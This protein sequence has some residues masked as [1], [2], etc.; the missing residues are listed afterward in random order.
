MLDDVGLGGVARFHNLPP[1]YHGLYDLRGVQRA[2]GGPVG[3]DAYTPRG[4]FRELR[5]RA[6]AAVGNAAP[7]PIAFEV[8][9]GFFPWF[10]PLDAGDD[11]D[12]ERDHVLS[13]LAAGIRGF[14]LYMA[15][16]RER[17]Y[18]AAIAQTGAAERHAGWIRTLIAA[19]VEVNWPELRRAAAIAVV[20]T[21][22]DARFGQASCVLD[23]LT[24][25]VSEVL[26]LGPG[27]G[28]ELGTDPAAI[29]QRRWQ[30]AITRALDVARVPYLLVEESLGEA[31]LAGMRAVIVPTL[32]R[33]DR[34]LAHT[35]RAVIEHGHADPAGRRT[36]VVIGPGTPTH[37][38]LGQP[39]VDA[40]PRRVGRLKPGSLDDV[41]GLAAD[42]AALADPAEAWQIERPDD[43]HAYAHHDPSGAVR[44]VFVASD[45]AKPTNA[46]L[47][48]D[49]TTRGLR[50]P[51]ARG[52][53]APAAGKAQVAL[54][55]R[56]VRMLIVER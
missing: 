56:G 29:T 30:A 3:I 54:P 24:P 53:I 50:D 33:I 34:G 8:G 49:E 11:P 2:I 6:L 36:V 19:L 40:L 25:V 52:R 26:G 20:D 1:G 48:V 46:V 37:D 5:R 15:V 55:P 9:V 41:P 31:E 18:G 27:G 42:L 45:A 32:E 13:L 14:N 51:F 47:L 7:V 44:V 16:E 10:P 39:L 38:E 23:P 43:V 4:E 17:Y 22:A 28:A 35:L 12:R 21:R